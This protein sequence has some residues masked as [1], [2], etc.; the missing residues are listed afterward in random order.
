MRYK[1][2]NGNVIDIPVKTVPKKS[3]GAPENQPSSILIDL[4]SFVPLIEDARSGKLF[5]RNSLRSYIRDINS[6]DIDRK[7]EVKQILEVLSYFICFDKIMLDAR[8]LEAFGS[9]HVLL[10]MLFMFGIDINFD[11]IDF[12]DEYYLSAN[13]LVNSLKTD[14]LGAK[15]PNNNSIEKML[16]ISKKTDFDDYIIKDMCDG[17][18]NNRF[19]EPRL[20][21]VFGNGNS[22]ESAERLLTYFEVASSL[23]VPMAASRKKYAAIK[24]LGD[25]IFSWYHENPNLYGE[26]PSNSGVESI[27]NILSDATNTTNSIRIPP[28]PGHI[29]KISKELNMSLIEAAIWLRNSPTAVHFREW[30]WKSRN[31]LRATFSDEALEM[32]KLK[33]EIELLGE[34]LKSG[35]GAESIFHKTSKFNFKISSIPVLG[36]FISNSGLNVLSELNIPLP[37]ISRRNPPLYEIFMANWFSKESIL[38]SP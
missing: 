8:A 15:K 21:S 20:G 23:D 11:F 7:N 30:V 5:S 10:D 9:S 4:H 17:Y 18:F 14:L 38:I 32:N 24:L 37:V 26:S 13:I 31:L 1:S 29:I 34:Q 35:R 36:S 2:S 28:L 6:A 25:K 16:K 19:L 33:S 3:E 27:Q 12:T 22:G